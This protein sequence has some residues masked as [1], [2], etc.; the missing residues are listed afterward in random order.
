VQYWLGQAAHA[1]GDFVGAVESF[2]AACD[3]AADPKLSPVL[4]DALA[5]RSAALVNISR[6]GE[7]IED[8]RRAVDL[9]RRMGYPAGEALASQNL[10]LSTYYAGDMEEALAWARQGQQI[11]AA[12][13]PGWIARRGI[14]LLM[15]VL[16]EIDVAA[17]WQ[18]GA[19]GLDQARQA[20]D[21]Q[22]QASCLGLMADLD[23][24]AGRIPEAA[25]HL[26]ESLE[27]ATRTGYTL[28][29]MNSVDSCGH[30]C[31]VTHRPAEAITLWAAYHA[32]TE[33]DGLIDLPRD[34]QS[35]QA[36]LREAEQVL[37]PD[38]TRAAEQRGAAMTQ[39]TAAEFATMLTA[40]GPQEQ[41]G[42]AQLSPR[43]RELV[44]LVAQ[45]CTNAQIA[46]QLYISVRTVSSHL[47]RIRDKTGCRRR[48]DLTRLAL[49]T[50]LV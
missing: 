33:E 16:M 12:A 18:C 40:A 37:G 49:Q 7:G 36:P 9:A 2:T 10:G 31:A 34:M 35:R 42:A 26:R 50:G 20:G 17:A 14:Y 22:S 30:L 41:P 45:G 15:L 5:G 27:I 28:G 24:L 13:I 48:A 29:V 25:A 43:E 32:R 6:I 4:V 19:D 38:R 47:D 3:A 1:T 39:A 8:A 11:G 23:R 21:L 46:G 44:T